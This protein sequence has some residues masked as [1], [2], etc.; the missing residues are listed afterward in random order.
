MSE[1][2]EKLRANK[3]RGMFVELVHSEHGNIVHLIQHENS[4]NDKEYEVN[5]GEVLQYVI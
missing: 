1:V 2:M 3:Y 4:I 5:D